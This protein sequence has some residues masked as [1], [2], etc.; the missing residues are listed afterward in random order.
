MVRR[1]IKRT[2]A[3]GRQNGLNVKRQLNNEKL[4]TKIYEEKEKKVNRKILERNSLFITLDD[5]LL[6]CC[7]PELENTPRNK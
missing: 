7:A 1:V 2:R 6:E 4:P 5:D 3:E